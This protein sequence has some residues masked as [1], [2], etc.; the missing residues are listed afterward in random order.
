MAQQRYP[1]QDHPDIAI[2]LNN[3]GYRLEE[4]GSHQEALQYHKQSLA[5][6]QRLY[7]DQDHPDIA[8]SLNDVGYSVGALGS[9]QE[10]LA[11]KKQAL[12]DEAAALSRPRSSRH[13]SLFKQCGLQFMGARHPPGGFSIS[14]AGISDV[15]AVL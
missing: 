6:R 2:S 7:P 1:D 4:L 12:S 5:M 13:C 15:A 11:Y 14:Q 10:A 8:A 9:Q 3:L